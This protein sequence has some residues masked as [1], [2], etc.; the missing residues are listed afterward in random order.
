[1]Q[2]T[3]EERFRAGTLIEM[4]PG[5]NLMFESGV[6]IVIDMHSASLYDTA[7]VQAL[8][9]GEAVWMDCKNIRRARS[10]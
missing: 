2:A 10:A 5:P 3:I 6:G 1:M 7:S 4:L 9:N 8:F